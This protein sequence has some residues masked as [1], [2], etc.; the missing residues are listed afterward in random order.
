M[1]LSKDLFSLKIFPLPHSARQGDC[2]WSTVNVVFCF[3]VFV[4]MSFFKKS[5]PTYKIQ[6]P[7]IIVIHATD[8][9]ENRRYFLLYACVLAVGIPTDQFFLRQLS[10]SV[11][12]II[13]EPLDD[14][15]C[16]LGFYNHLQSKALRFGKF[17]VA[18]KMKTKSVKIKK[19]EVTVSNIRLSRLDSF[20]NMI[21]CCVSVVLVCLLFHVLK[22]LGLLEDSKCCLQQ[23]QNIEGQIQYRLWS[24]VS[25]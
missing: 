17:S 25:P 10:I 24:L 7:F 19:S 22:N 4:C 12:V 20:I 6:R 2:L 1:F 23:R 13:F 5:S 18:F 16:P 3:T 14:R 11:F 9:A 15:F 8:P 21:Y